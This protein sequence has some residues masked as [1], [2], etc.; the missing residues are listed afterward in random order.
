M[1]PVSSAVKHNRAY[2]LEFDYRVGEIKHSDAN[3]SPPL[4]YFFGGCAA[5][6]LSRGVGPLH[7]LHASTRR[8]L[9][10]NYLRF[11]NHVFRAYSGHNLTNIYK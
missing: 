11:V 3:D 10:N 4:R 5:H 1:W 8:R 9:K 7:L 2:G 6:A